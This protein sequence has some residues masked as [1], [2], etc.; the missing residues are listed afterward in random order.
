MSDYEWA[1]QDRTQPKQAFMVGSIFK[2]RDEEDARTK[3]HSFGYTV[4]KRLPGGDWE[5]A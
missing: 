3:A 2:A 5:E 4:M 1:T